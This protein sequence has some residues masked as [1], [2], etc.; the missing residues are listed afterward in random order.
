MGLMLFATLVTVMVVA[1]HQ[2]DL[3]LISIIV[4]DK[5]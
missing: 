1:M 4:K 3:S 5:W 2:C